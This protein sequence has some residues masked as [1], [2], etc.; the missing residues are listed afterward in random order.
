[1]DA[2]TQSPALH[3]LFASFPF[4]LSCGGRMVAGF[5]EASTLGTHLPRTGDSAGD[6]FHAIPAGHT[7]MTLRRGLVADPSFLSWIKQSNAPQEQQG[8]SPPTC[9][10]LI[11]TVF[12]ETGHPVSSHP[13]LASCA[14]GFSV[15]DALVGS[16][17][18]AAL[19]VLQVTCRFT[20]PCD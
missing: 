19:A 17:G 13:L 16:Q 2:D 18:I 10:D 1:M 8:D 15:E 6:P 9:R 11:L 3:D 12:G 5:H 14:C 20:P 7:I 4:R